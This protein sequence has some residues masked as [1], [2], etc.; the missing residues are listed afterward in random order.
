MKTPDTERTT[1]G[2]APP[3]TTSDAGVTL[4]PGP[5]SRVRLLG[6]EILRGLRKHETTPLSNAQHLRAAVEWLAVSQRATG[7]EGSA[8]AYNLV[9]GWGGPYPETTGYIV[10]TLY[11]YAAATG[12]EAASERAERMAE[13]LLTT[14]FDHGGFPAGDSPDTETEP[15]VFN[16]GQILFGLV[17]AYEETGD[18]RYREAVRRAGEWLVEVQDEA[19]YWDRFD[20]HDT[21]HSYSSRVGWAL[22]RASEVTGEAAFREAASANLHWVARQARGDGWFDHCGFEPGQEPFLHTLAYTVRGL[23][24]GG[25]ALGDDELVAVATRSADA[26]LT[27]QRRDG[28]LRGQYDESMRPGDYYC[29]TGNAQMAVVWYRLF[30]ETGAA[31]YREAGD[32]TVAFL[33]TRQRMDGPAV[34]RGGLRGSSPVWGRYMYLRYPNWAAKFLVDALL[35]ADRVADRP[36]SRE[37]DLIA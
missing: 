36:P 19:G 22:V 8:S 18:E 30:E 2:R 27:R 33:K 35:L 14:Q 26:L 11:D 5:V 29:L 13:W 15:S 4:H 1:T 10:P 9:L 24:E 20:Y 23:L 31:K 16:T 21:V 34:V 6:S 3:S 25:F 7:T 28:I 12:D 37:H 32:E 17:R